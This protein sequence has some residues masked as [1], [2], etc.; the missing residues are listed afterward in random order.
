MDVHSQVKHAAAGEGG[1]QFISTAHRAAEQKRSLRGMNTEP[2]TMKNPRASP[3]VARVRAGTSER[4]RKHDVQN[5][6]FREM[7]ACT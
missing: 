5:N 6:Y 7:A 1:I 2:Q 4:E 3:K